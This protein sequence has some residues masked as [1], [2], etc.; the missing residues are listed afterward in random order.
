M[1][2]ARIHNLVFFFTNRFLYKTIKQ[3]NVSVAINGFLKVWCKEVCYADKSV[4]VGHSLM[5]VFYFR[6]ILMN[7]CK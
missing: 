3:L 1:F 7:S 2:L 5:Y 6:K 4:S